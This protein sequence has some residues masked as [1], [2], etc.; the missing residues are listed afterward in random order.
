MRGKK[1]WDALGLHA[2]VAESI[3]AY[4]R[5]SPPTEVQRRAAACVGEARLV[6]GET[7]CGKTL[8]YVAQLL[9]GLR[10]GGAEGLAAR[11][12]VSREKRPFGVVLVPTRE[13][14]AQVVDVVR[15]VGGAVVRGVVAGKG[16]GKGKLDLV[17][18]TPGMVERVWGKGD[19]FLSRVGHVVVDEADVLLKDGGDF[20]AQV[21]PLLDALVLK[22]RAAATDDDGRR[23]KVQFTYVAATVPR[24][25]KEGLEKRH[26]KLSI[27]QT[28]RLHVA[29]L[30]T[31]VRT[32]FIRV[33]GGVDAKFA[34]A[35][36]VTRT[37]LGRNDGSVMLFCDG[38]DRRADLVD[39]LREELG[40]PVVQLSATASDAQ[41]RKR[42]WESFSQTHAT[43]RVAVCAQSYGR[44][45]DHVGVRAVVMVDVPRTGGEY[46]HRIGRIRG[47]GRVYVLV[48]HREEAMAEALFLGHVDGKNIASVNA[49]SAWKDYMAAGR[50]RI[51]TE[52][53]VRRARRDL[54]A[55]WVDERSTAAGTAR[56]PRGR[57]R[58]QPSDKTGAP[59]RGSR[60]RTGRHE[61]RARAGNRRGSGG[62]GDA[63]GSDGLRSVPFL[64][65]W[66]GGVAAAKGAGGTHRRAGGSVRSAHEGG[67]SRR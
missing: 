30:L 13:L 12:G 6:A 32:A 10:G 18:G 24:G 49:A 31:D 7:G 19:L 9:S 35:V 5:G 57:A 14:V 38:E 46:L 15:G 2:G 45:I 11:V 26:G 20:E 8:A 53:G 58:G 27:A 34:K 3:H 23:A 64:S 63:G 56:A 22:S 17:V 44:G 37:A 29:P 54:H 41:G 25:L 61:P 21:V 51:S 47:K 1:G 4:L 67:G 16:C 39:M 66:Q 50:D 33:S 42:D 55:R 65:S 40:V 36:E 28:D 59:H 52:H 48:G 43:V 60:A 62:T